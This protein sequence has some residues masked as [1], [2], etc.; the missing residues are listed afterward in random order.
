MYISILMIGQYPVLF[1]LEHN[2]DLGYMII[3]VEISYFSM[4]YKLNTLYRVLSAA[5]VNSTGFEKT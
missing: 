2:F 5:T 1:N 4:L 3:E